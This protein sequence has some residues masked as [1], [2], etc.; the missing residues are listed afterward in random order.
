MTRIDRWR[1]LIGGA[2]TAVVCLGV[3][4]ALSSQG[5]AQAL[6]L[7][8]STVPTLRFLASTALTASATILAL[9][10]TVLGLSLDS[11]PRLVE[12][13]YERIRRIAYWATWGFLA[14]LLF[15]LLLT[16]PL[17][18]S[19]AIPPRW[20]SII[21]YSLMSLGSL[22]AG[23]V[24]TVVLMLYNTLSDMIDAVGLGRENL[25]VA[26]ESRQGP[27]IIVAE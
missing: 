5:D 17:Y 25:L 16:V 7:L 14:G 12:D 19:K 15:L 22:L 8:E 1:P 26:P 3:T 2:V 9:M 23:L 11:E 13:H 6:H 4:L 18:E 24:A 10:L 21:Y 20:Y 27:E